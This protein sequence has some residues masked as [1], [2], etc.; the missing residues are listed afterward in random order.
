MTQSCNVVGYICQNFSHTE[1][2]FIISNSLSVSAIFH[3]WTYFQ[4]Q[5][6]TKL[7]YYYQKATSQ[8]PKNLTERGWTYALHTRRNWAK[9]WMLEIYENLWW[10]RWRVLKIV[11]LFLQEKYCITHQG[12]HLLLIIVTPSI[13]FSEDFYAIAWIHSVCQG[14]RQVLIH[15]TF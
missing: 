1:Q 14:N 6:T 10:R 15:F 3:L 12:I 4:F 9:S 13:N 5:R 7:G 8:E 11:C 2:T